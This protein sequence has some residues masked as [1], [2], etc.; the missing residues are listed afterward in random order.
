MGI[1]E[2]IGLKRARDK[3]TNSYEG[4]DFSYLFGRTT[5]GKNVNEMTALQTTAVYACVRILAEAIASLPI[6]VYKHTDEGKEQDV[7]H[8]LYYLLHDEPN[9]DMTSFV[10][11][12]TLMSHL[13]IWGNAY[14]QIIRDGRGQVLALYPL[15]PDRMTVKRDD[16]GELYYVYQRSEEDNPNF[17]DKGNIILK[18]SEVLHVPGLGFDGLIGYSPI[19]MAKNAVGMTL[20]TEEY[21]ASFFAN[22]ANPGGV[23]EHPG[24]LKDPSK[25][26]ESWNQVY[27]GTNN[28][29]KVAVLEEGMIYKTIGIPPN[30]AQFLET[31]KFQ[32]NEIARLYRIPPHMVGD[33]EKSSFSNIEQQSLEFVKYTLDPWVV[34][35]EQAFQKALLLPDEKKTYFIKFNVDGLLRGDYQSRMNGYAIG[36]QNGWL[37]TNDIRRLEDM[38]PLSKEEGGDLY[39]V[40]GNM[41]KLEDAGGFIKDA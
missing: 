38:N 5:S 37:S 26:R 36:R 19:A 17:K 14:A 24:I 11:R 30:E 31:R 40:N 15:L 34:R 41:T 1:L 20:A 29:H 39:L 18:K 22:G 35:F 10:F 7:N 21:G 6:H 12:E 32:I 3:P 4:S 8:Q 27:Q 25:V 9:P 23:L 2:L 33:L 16:K 28:S 13:L